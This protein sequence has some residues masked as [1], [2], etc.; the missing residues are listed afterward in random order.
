MRV[1]KNAR[2]DLQMHNRYHPK[3]SIP[4]HQAPS[5]E[6][7]KTTTACTQQE[8]HDGVV[9]SQRESLDFRR[10]QA[11]ASSTPTTTRKTITVSHFF[12]SPHYC[13]CV[14]SCT[15]CIER[16]LA[17]KR[18]DGTKRKRS[19]VCHCNVWKTEQQSVIPD[20]GPPRRCRV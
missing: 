16:T 13:L 12:H 10:E 15:Y 20:R 17:R 3:S 9:V 7:A 14:V 11:S 4:F 1:R 8:E 19:A 6:S 18:K 5:T 2:F